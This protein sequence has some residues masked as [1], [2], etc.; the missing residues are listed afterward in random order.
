MSRYHDSCRATISA[1]GAVVALGLLAACNGSDK[2]AS[3]M[4]SAINPKVHDALSFKYANNPG[5]E[6][7]TYFPGFSFDA[8]QGEHWIEGPRQPEPE[9]NDFRPRPR[10]IFGKILPQD[11]LRR[12]H[13]VVAFV[14]TM[15]I[16][17]QATS[18]IS[19]NPEEFL[20]YQLRL[21]IELD[22][23]GSGSGR[24][25]MIS[26]QGKLIKLNGYNCARY[27]SVSEDHGVMGFRG[28]PFRT[29]THVIQCLAPS[30]TFSVIMTYSQR[31]PPD[32]KP[33]DIT[34]EGEKFLNSLRFSE[35]PTG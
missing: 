12:P 7:I 20:Q 1:L 19:V 15:R 9:P 27:D 21:T 23:V 17:P 25:K 32:V 28:L 5:P 8:P 4:V 3:G 22:K 31:T 30:Y 2:N 33:V 13:T 10:M 14:R 29:E 26:Q 18:S 11:E 35:I 16:H 6:R 24:H 34:R